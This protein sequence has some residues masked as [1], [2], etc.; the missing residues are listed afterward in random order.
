MAMKGEVNTQNMRRYAPKGHPPRSLVGSRR[1]ACILP[2]LAVRD[3]L[4]DLF[5]SNR[6]NGL[7]HDVEWPPRSLGGVH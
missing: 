3:R 1:R 6:V 5:G 4:N 2:H 7:G